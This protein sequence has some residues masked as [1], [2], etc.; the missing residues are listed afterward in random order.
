MI[1]GTSIKG[2]GWHVSYMGIFCTNVFVAL[3]AVYLGTRIAHLVDVNNDDDER[4]IDVPLTISSQ[5]MQGA[6]TS[7]EKF[8]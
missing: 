8:D 1:Q 3:N 7:D 5:L 4:A 2:G 6:L